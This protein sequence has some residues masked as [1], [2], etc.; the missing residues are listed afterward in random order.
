MNREIDVN[1]I[2]KVE[3]PFIIDIREDDEVKETGTING[4]LH[5]PMSEIK[6]RLTE[7]PKDRDV[8]ILCRSGQR[9]KMT[10]S[11]LGMLGYK[12]VNLS[13]GIIN[14]KGKLYK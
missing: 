9:S 4:A 6:D 11:F 10:S 5:I 3:N 12:T 8:Y 2:D 1:E 13:G 14:Y 7:I